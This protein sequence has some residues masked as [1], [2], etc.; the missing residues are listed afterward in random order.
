MNLEVE[1]LN[2]TGSSKCCDM[3]PAKVTW[4]W[5]GRLPFLYN[6]EQ[7]VTAAPTLT[8]FSGSAL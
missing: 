7:P 5:Y 3:T 1:F 4:S 8:H 2:D 6:Q